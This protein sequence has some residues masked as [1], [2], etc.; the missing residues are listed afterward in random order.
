MVAGLRPKEHSPY[1]VLLADWMLIPDLVRA[2][3]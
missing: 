2:G 3:L 1:P